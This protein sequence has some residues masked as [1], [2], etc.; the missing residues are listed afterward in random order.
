MFEMLYCALIRFANVLIAMLGDSWVELMIWVLG[1][2]PD[3]DF[4][5][6]PIEW[7]EF[8]QSI[9]YFI[10]VPEMAADFAK[11]MIAYGVFLSVQHILKLVKLIG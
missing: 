4:S 1:F 7:G 6:P 8:G 5:A 11:I 3:A 2:L 10:P 9:G